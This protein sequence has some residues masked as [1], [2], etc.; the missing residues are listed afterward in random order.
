MNVSYNLVAEEGMTWSEWV[1]SDY[2]TVGAFILCDLIYFETGYAADGQYSYSV[3][4]GSSEYIF[5]PGGLTC[6]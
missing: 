6:D 2:N 3:I 1:E 5:A 4:Q